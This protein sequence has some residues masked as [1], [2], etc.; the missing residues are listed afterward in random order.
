MSIVR[1][2]F[3]RSILQLVLLVSAAVALSETKVQAFDEWCQGEAGECSQLCGTT[4]SWEVVGTHP[5]ECCRLEWS[6]A[7]QGLVCVPDSECP[8]YN[9]YYASGIEI[10][11]C[12]EGSQTSLCQCAY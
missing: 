4:V 11:E 1:E 7:L 8:V 6:E 5:E 10:F 9:Y 3:I 2:T 12:D